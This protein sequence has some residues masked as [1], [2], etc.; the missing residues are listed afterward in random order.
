MKIQIRNILS[1]C[2]A[3]LLICALMPAT[4]QAQP[5]AHYTP[6]VEGIK[7][8]S[9]P[10]P[11]VYF[12]DY[13]LFYYATTLNTPAG[14]DGTPPDF[15]AFTYAQVP[16]VL[17]ITDTKILGGY[18]G[19][20]ALLP[21]LYQYVRIP[22]VIDHGTFGVGDLFGE[23][24]VSWHLPQWDFA[25]AGGVWA[26]TGDSPNKNDLLPNGKVLST[27][28]GLGYWTGMLTAGGTWY[29]DTNR[30]WA[31][32]ALNR[33]EFNAEQQNTGS[34]PGQAYTLEYAISKT[35]AKVYDVG[36]VGYYQQQVTEDSGTG[37][38][39]DRDRVA[40]IG[41]EFSVAFPQCMTF[42]SVRYIYEYLS[43]DRAQ[44]HTVTLTLT[45]R[46]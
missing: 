29:I 34:T 22:G 28:A 18:L 33:Y 9:L 38:S 26:P 2:S 1:C 41:G 3:A 7:A 35:L 32:S 24:T 31:V 6:G 14:K 11:G 15:K 43:E 5:T 37:S 42:V 8:A 30:T 23:A 40:G 39:G 13:N 4:V 19:V 17:W 12:R 46:F 10:P 21:L 45:K 20:D 16:R 36:A 27:R 44:G 25:V